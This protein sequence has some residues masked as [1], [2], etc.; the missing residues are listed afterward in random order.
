MKI[1]DKESVKKFLEV[2]DS[3]DGHV[4]LTSPWGDRYNLKSELSRYVAVAELIK[5]KGDLL[6]LYCQLS[7]DEDRFYKFFNDNPEVLR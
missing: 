1:K 7:A 2:V 4:W 3:C 6:E 5:T